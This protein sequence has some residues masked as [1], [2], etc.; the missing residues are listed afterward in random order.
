MET[1]LAVDPNALTALELFTSFGLP[2]Q[3]NYSW[4]KYLADADS[5]EKEIKTFANGKVSMIM[6][7]TY[8]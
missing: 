6:G 5:G 3:K 4:N 7:Y 1:T 8:V 2:S